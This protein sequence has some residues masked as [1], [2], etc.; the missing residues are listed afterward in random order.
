MGSV[1][2]D[3]E[4]PAGSSDRHSV[5]TE[6]ALEVLKQ[7]TRRLERARIATAAYQRLTDETPAAGVLNLLHAK[8]KKEQLSVGERLGRFHLTSELGRGFS[9]VVYKAHHAMLDIDVALKVLLDRNLDEKSLA[10]VYRE[11][12]LLATLNHP[13]IIRILDF[14]RIDDWH[15]VILEFVDGLSLRTLSEQQGPMKPTLVI[16]VFAQAAEALRYAHTKGVV[17]NDIKPANILLMK[18]GMVKVADLGMAK[19]VSQGHDLASSTQVCGTPAYISPEMVS[20]GLRAADHRSDMYSLGVSM[21][22]CL[23]GQLPFTHTDPYQLMVAHVQEEA[24]PLTALIK[25]IDIGL[26]T[27]VACMMS[28]RPEDRP[29]DYRQLLD[30]L[31]VI[32]ES[33]ENTDEDSTHLELFFDQPQQPAPPGPVQNQGLLNRLFRRGK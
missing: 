27:L 26:A 16:D 10:C 22:Q 7:S 28:K 3:H 9:S 21:F 11:S 30:D 13:G 5:P 17:H 19:V 31:K 33:L 29:Q 2:D 24:P 14:D 4:F 23:S 32:Q 12:H 8:G 15:I 18:D 6:H 1:H 20:Q 25:H